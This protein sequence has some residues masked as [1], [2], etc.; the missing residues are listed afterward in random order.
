LVSLS[1]RHLAM[2]IAF[3]KKVHTESN[4]WYL[5]LFVCAFNMVLRETQLLGM[6]KLIINMHIRAYICFLQ[7]GF[8]PMK[9]Y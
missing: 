1:A 7:L 6:E 3:P 9:F 8:L 5:F 4:L 2:L